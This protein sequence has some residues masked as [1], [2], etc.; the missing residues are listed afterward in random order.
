[1]K[2]KNEKIKA[3]PL[4]KTDKSHT[5][6]FC[7][8]KI[9]SFQNMITHTILAVQKYKIMDII[10]AS[11]INIC[12]Q[13]LEVLFKELSN[14]NSKINNRKSFD[15]AINDLQKINNELSALFRTSGTYNIEDLLLVAMGNDFLKFC[16]LI[17]NE[18]Q[19]FEVIKAHVHPISYKVM[20]WRDDKKKNSK[21]IHKNRII[22]DFMI[23]E[24][25]KNFDCFDLARTSKDFQKKVYGIKLAI[26]NESEK[27]T[28]IISGIVDDILTECTNHKFIIEKLYKLQ[29]NKP[30]DTSLN[31][32]AYKRYVS[33]LTIKELLIYNIHELH[34]RFIGYS[35]QINLIKQKP[36]SQNVKEFISSELY[37]QRRV[38]IQLLMK[39]DDPEF[40]Y[41]AYLLYDLLSNDNNGSIDTVE[42]T[43]LFDSLPW[44]IKKYFRDA[45]KTT[46]RY[47]NTLAKFDNSKIPIEQQICLLK[48]SDS[49]KEKAMVKLKEVKAKSEDSGSKARQYLDGLLKIPFGVYRKEPILSIMENIKINFTDVI[50]NIKENNITLEIPHDNVLTSLE[51]A[52]YFPTIKQN[53]ETE[54]IDTNTNNIV[55]IFCSGKRDTLIANTCY[56]NAIIKKLRLKT[57]RLCHS[58]KKNDFMR[59]NL[60]KFIVDN[61]NNKE[62]IQAIQKRFPKYFEY[63]NPFQLLDKINVIDND[64][65]KISDVINTVD[66]TLEKSVHGHKQA[67]RQLQRII[68]Q[69]LNGEQKGHCFGFEGAPGVGK[70]TLAKKGLAECLKDDNGEVRPFAFIPIGGSSNGS[71][72]SGHNYTYVG[73]TWGRIVD[74]LME[75]KC[76]NPIIFIDELDKVSRSEHGKEI[77][78]ILTHLVD[79]SQN[80]SFQ[81]KYFTGIDLDLSKA[82]FIFS[83]NDPA[84]IDKILLDRIHRIKFECLS[85]E[86]KLVITKDYILPEIFKKVGLN[87]CVTFTDEIIELI[88]DSYTYEPGVRKLKEIL[89]EIISEV[90]LDILQLKDID[91]PLV[92]TKDDIKNKFLKERPEIKIKEIH[93]NPSVGIVTGLWAN[94]LGKGGI[95]PIETLFYPASNPMDFK[96]T[97]MQGD[98][99]KESM[100]VAKSLAWKLTS[101]KKKKK[102]SKE[103]SDTKLQ[104]IHIHCPEGATPKDGPSAGTAITV[105]IFSLLN[106][107]KV[108]NNI[109]I[110]GE[111]TLQGQVT[112]IGGLKLKILGGIKAGVKEFIYPKENQKDFN[113]FWEVYGE[114]PIVKNIKFNAVK[115]IHDVFKLVF[116]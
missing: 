95:I 31:E 65:S 98:V 61:K 3:N 19:I 44:N 41:L 11:D 55:N 88:I 54:I 101:T 63:T 68:G 30:D 26:H 81:D 6:S 110:T 111:I 52:K 50:K 51:I 103:F 18:T 104:G 70:T 45:M 72:L 113:K 58:G 1:M 35:N 67:K 13:N 73:S 43:I 62:I 87:N 92:L 15:D 108:K 37:G 84:L 99:M 83:Y 5:L 78:G 23:V 16:N 85:V 86:D 39:N 69:W 7:K 82:L 20:N 46:I 56:V 79:E 89:Y 34:Q 42:Q 8:S 28:I 24:T 97:G 96:L 76:M 14:L 4:K 12:I 25:S 107:K 102:I 21:K 9:S 38:L 59:N 75:K 90:N 100:N 53:A 33:S 29:T 36:I 32:N 66:S 27:K 115:S 49:V 47:T 94:A 48:V 114:K 91:L 40:Q 105:A 116:V 80:D 93:E 64:L 109:A 74:I 71:T 60:K 2:K 17:D 57:N 22:D 106:N 112:Q 10:S 77:I